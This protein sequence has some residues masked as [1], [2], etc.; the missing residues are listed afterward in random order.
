MLKSMF[1]FEHDVKYAPLEETRKNLLKQYKK[2]KI[3]NEKVAAL[4]NVT[5]Q[6][7]AEAK[8]DA[9]IL[10]KKSTRVFWGSSGKKKYSATS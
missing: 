3:S 2:N 5:E 9:S 1:G 6:V 4:V 7:L 10:S 8:L